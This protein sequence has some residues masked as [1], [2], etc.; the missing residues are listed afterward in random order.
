[1]KP[2]FLAE[3]KAEYAE[4]RERYANRQPKAPKLSY[5]KSIA[6]KFSHDWNNYTPPKPKIFSTKQNGLFLSRAFLTEPAG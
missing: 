2:I 1:M 6:E 4:V 3:R 5:E